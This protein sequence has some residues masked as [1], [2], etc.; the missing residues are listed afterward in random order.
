[1]ASA[2]RSRDHEPAVRIVKGEPLDE[3]L[4]A[5]TAVLLARADALPGVSDTAD[6]EGPPA[7]WR[8]VGYAS[9][10][11]WHRAVPAPAK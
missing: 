5:L 11:S 7:R 4:A 9:P 2:P 3:E 6:E 10:V 8:P 1:M